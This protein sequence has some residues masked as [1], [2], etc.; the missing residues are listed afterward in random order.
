[1]TDNWFSTR[2]KKKRSRRPRWA[3]RPRRVACGSSGPTLPSVAEYDPKRD[4][5]YP[6]ISLSS[7]S[8][9]S[10]LTI[11]AAK[12]VRHGPGARALPPH[13]AT[14]GKT[15]PS[16]REAENESFDA[17]R[18][19]V[20]DFVKLRSKGGWIE[21][22]K[23]RLLALR[24]FHTSATFLPGGTGYYLNAGWSERPP[25]SLTPWP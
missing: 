18:A 5:P 25:V 4:V 21:K 3:R 11:E 2:H 13:T 14:D 9:A 23:A 20:R 19:M 12:S 22:S 1:M 17:V 7:S 16:R 6:R 10:Y 8:K 24:V 15:R